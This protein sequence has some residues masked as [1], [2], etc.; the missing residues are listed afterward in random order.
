MVTVQDDFTPPVENDPELV[1][2][3]ISSMRSIAGIQNVIKVDPATV[4]EDFGRYGRTAENVKI[5][6]FWLG[7]VNTSKYQQSISKSLT[8]PALH[9]EFFYPDFRPAYITG[10]SAMSRAIIDLLQAK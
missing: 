6:L 7:G 4:A 1:T 10:A 9:S 8:L 3:A 5:G 2:G